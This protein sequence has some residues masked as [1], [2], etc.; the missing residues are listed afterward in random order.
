MG[1]HVFTNHNS[2]YIVLSADA[3]PSFSE[4]SLLNHSYEDDPLRGEDEDPVEMW[5]RAVET[6]MLNDSAASSGAL[7]NV[8]NSARKRKH[9]SSESATDHDIAESPL[10]ASTALRPRSRVSRRKTAPDSAEGSLSTTMDQTDPDKS[11]VGVKVSKFKS[12]ER[13]SLEDK[14]LKSKEE[15]SLQK[16]V[17]TPSAKASPES[18]RRSPRIQVMSSVENTPSGRGATTEAKQIVD[19][20]TVSSGRQLLDACS[21]GKGHDENSPKRMAPSNLCALIEVSSESHHQKS[22][23]T[24]K[25]S[26][27]PPAHTSSEDVKTPL[28][29]RSASGSLRRRAL[30]NSAIR[31]SE[32]V[33][34]SSSTPL[35]TANGTERISEEMAE[36]PKT[37]RAVEK[38]TAM[39]ASPSRRESP[40][41]E[42]SSKTSAPGK[43]SPARTV[44]SN[45][46]D[47]PKS[48]SSSKKKR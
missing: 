44:S 23:L 1:S 7:S 21:E 28:A 48:N 22:P 5:N 18:K 33:E 3:T 6:S 36:T 2:N 39:P 45:R 31:S 41:K 17:A 19:R 30:L 43:S 40:R 11:T 38:N 25:I 9:D 29:R 16:A 42:I 37:G 8:L 4:L 20:S 47:T 35:G 13:K 32:K 10:A 12:Y 34:K 46:K 15:P 26:E 24:I 14:S 27:E